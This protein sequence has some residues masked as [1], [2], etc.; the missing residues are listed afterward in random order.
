MAKAKKEEKT[1][2]STI[3]REIKIEAFNDE[4]VITRNGYKIHFCDPNN[5]GKTI[6]DLINTGKVIGS[7]NISI[8]T[9]NDKTDDIMLVVKD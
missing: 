7:V 9:P 3:K 1:I 6:N 5:D 8:L 2:S 4:R